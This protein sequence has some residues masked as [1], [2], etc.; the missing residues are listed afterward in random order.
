MIVKGDTNAPYVV[1]YTECWIS[2]ILT[3]FLFLILTLQ[4]WLLM[5][6]SVLFAN[7]LNGWEVRK[8][9]LFYMDLNRHVVWQHQAISWTNVNFS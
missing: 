7:E 9:W 3:V 1:M 8:A 5:Q 6:I 2:S 4:I